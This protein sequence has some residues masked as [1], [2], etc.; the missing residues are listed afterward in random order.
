MTDPLPDRLP[1]VIGVTGHR[2]LRDQDIPRLEREV[3][4]VLASL[5][6]DFLGKDDETPVIVLSAL[7]EGAD[8]LVARVAV[9]QGA[10]LIVPLPMPLDEYRRDF[11]PGLKLGNIAE[12]DELFAHAIAAPVMP[13]HAASVEALRADQ[14]KRDAQYRALASSLSSTAMSCSPSGMATKKSPVPAAQPRLLRSNA[15]GFRS[16]SAARHA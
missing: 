7:A 16:M 11:E 3:A 15:T 1:L 4:A 10:R 12:F 5:R 14:D 8:R 6:R 2:D 13:L 9:A